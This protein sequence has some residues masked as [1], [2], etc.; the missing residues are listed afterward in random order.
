MQITFETNE[1]T[2]EWYCV[3]WNDG[4]KVWHE[5]G[6]TALEAEKKMKAKLMGLFN[7]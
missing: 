2:G 1:R 7:A 4:M 5:I 6:D 3:L